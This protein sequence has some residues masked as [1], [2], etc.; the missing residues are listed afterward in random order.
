MFRVIAVGRFDGVHLGHQHLLSLAKKEAQKL[1]W[2]VLAYTFPPQYPALLPLSAKI[3]LLRR[4]VDEVEVG[5]WEKVRVLSPE[6]FLR[7]EIV[8][9]L[10]GRALVMGP[11][12]RF[13]R[14]RKGDPELARAIGQ[15]LNLKVMVVPPFFV[16]GKAVS[17]RL[18]RELVEQGEVVRAQELLGRPPV[19]FGQVVPGVGLGKNLGFPTLNLALDPVQVRPKEGVYLSWVFWPDG[20]GPALFYHGRRPTFPTLPPSSEVHLLSSPPS[21]PPEILE[22]HVLRFLRPDIRFPSPAALVEQIKKDVAEAERSL[23]T[24]SP[25]HPILIGV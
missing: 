5:E 22:I 24:F 7:E 13:G 19:L 8:G 18:I 10:R 2:S 12:H 25:P 17:S 3:A 9:R 21:S 11:D 15:A 6:E 4:F 23:Q 14:D 20:H 16:A 1:G